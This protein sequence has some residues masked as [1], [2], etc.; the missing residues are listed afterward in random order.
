MNVTAVDAE[1]VLEYKMAHILHKLITPV[2]VILAAVS[3]YIPSHCG[4]FHLE[5]PLMWLVM[6]LAHVRPWIE[7]N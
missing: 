6:A 3:Y 5:M 4:G 2:C 1:K 7:R